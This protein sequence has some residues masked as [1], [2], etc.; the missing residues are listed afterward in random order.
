MFCIQSALCNYLVVWWYMT[1]PM[2][3]FIHGRNCCQNFRTNLPIWGLSLAPDGCFNPICIRW[4]DQLGPKIKLH[5]AWS[6]R[7][8]ASMY[9]EVHALPY[10]VCSK[11]PYSATSCVASS[12]FVTRIAEKKDENV[13]VPLQSEVRVISSQENEPLH[14]L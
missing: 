9:R 11:V 10:E 2:D 4:N 7:T 12:R 13:T 3:F 6:N 1:L 5:V 8:V 14:G